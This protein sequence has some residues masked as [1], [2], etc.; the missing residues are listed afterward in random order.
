MKAV[1]DDIDIDNEGTSGAITVQ[2]E[3]DFFQDISATNAT[4]NALS[5]YPYQTTV[6]Q[7]ASVSADKNTL[8]DRVCLGSVGVKC[9]A[10]DAG[11]AIVVTYHFE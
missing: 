8:A 10:I 5:A 3:D 2:L 9:N 1:I 6:A 7:N 11:C 4:I